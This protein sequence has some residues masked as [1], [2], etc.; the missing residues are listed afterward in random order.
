MDWKTRRTI[1]LFSFL[2]LLITNLTPTVLANN[3]TN[4]CTS[5]EQCANRTIDCE[6]E[7]S[8][9]L[10]C[11]GESSCRDATVICPSYGSCNITCAAEE[12]CYGM[13]VIIAEGNSQFSMIC[14]EIRSCRESIIATDVDFNETTSNSTSSSYARYFNGGSGDVSSIYLECS[15]ASSCRDSNFVLTS[16][17]TVVICSGAYSCHTTVIDAQ[18]SIKLN[19]TA[20]GLWACEYA[21]LLSNF[22]Y[23]LV[24]LKLLFYC[25]FRL[26]VACKTKGKCKE[27]ECFQVRDVET[28][29]IAFSW[30]F[31]LF[32][33]F[34]YF[35]SIL[36]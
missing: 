11:S 1:S 6:D 25:C 29:F 18:G 32:F 21:D 28:F 9:S 20:S 30:F 8:C 26:S 13:N 3:D 35:V 16:N 23:T 10:T 5:Y 31:V 17:A 33:V 27:L 15:G 36:F 14:S 2:I 22:F 7:T 12:A 24:F 19:F 4:Q 34:S